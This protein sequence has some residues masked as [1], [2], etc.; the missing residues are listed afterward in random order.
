MADMLRNALATL[1][2]RMKAFNSSAVT[3]RR[4][5]SSIVGVLASYGTRRVDT[6]D[7]DNVM[8]TVTFHDFVIDAADLEVDGERFEPERG[9]RI[10]SIVDGVLQA[11]EVSSQGTTEGIWRYTDSTNLRVRIHTHLKRAEDA[12]EEES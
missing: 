2:Q 11:F 10:E 12:P 6:F 4:G 1:G 3:Y 8:V 5:A 9:D 7:S